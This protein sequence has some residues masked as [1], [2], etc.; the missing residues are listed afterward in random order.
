MARPLSPERLPQLVEAATRIF[1]A[2]GY[3]NTQMADVAE[4]VGVAKGTLYGYVAS[5]EA[6]LD[7]AIRFA[8]GQG[9]LPAPD[10]LPLPTPAPGS[11]VK[12]IQGRLTG[13]V[14]QLLLVQAL[15]RPSGTRPER[16]EFE[17]IL[18]DL[19]RR[20]LRNRR[21]LKLVDRCAVDHPELA[22]VWFKQGRYGLVA[23]LAAY[24]EKGAHEGRL[25]AGLNVQ[26]TARLILETIALWTIHMPWDAAPQ[27][28]TDE[29]VE[30]V[31]LDLLVHAYAKERPR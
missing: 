27:T 1:V 31:V 3:R 8:D 16:R 4:A 23:L 14:G 19:H 18:R 28:L 9:T 25:R 26:L 10:M 6:L 11:T 22:A 7:A 30:S 2:K 24:L 29:E 15:S 12:Y 17:S 20:M 13:E 5:K 21:A